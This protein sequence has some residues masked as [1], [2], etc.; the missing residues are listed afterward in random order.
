MNSVGAPGAEASARMDFSQ[1]DL[2]PEFELNEILWW[3]MRGP[4][5]PMPPPVHAAS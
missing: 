3:S 2:T 1:A 4:M 5:S